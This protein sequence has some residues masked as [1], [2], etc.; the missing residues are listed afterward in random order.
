MKRFLLFT[1][2]I[3]LF[4]VQVNADLWELDKTTA[5]GF[6]EELIITGT[7][8]EETLSVYDGPTTK[9]YGPGPA[10][11]GPMSGLVGFFGGLTGDVGFPNY[12]GDAKLEIYDSTPGL[13][14]DIDYGG[15]TAYFENDNQS[16]WSVQLFYV[17]STDGTRTSA[18]VELA[19]L[20]GSAWLTAPASGLTALDLDNI[21]KIGLR[22]WGEH[23][24]GTDLDYQSYSDDFHVSLVPVPAAVI[25][26][27]L[28]LGAAGWKLRK[29]A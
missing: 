25:L 16:I 7:Q 23:M 6:T 3:G 17:D 18:W 1:L 8:T 19:G 29:F 12:D 26:G 11:Y 15:I 21:T 27:M 10:E 20:G 13:S 4:A 28:G 9:V 14:G 2:V 24:G 5:L 22:I